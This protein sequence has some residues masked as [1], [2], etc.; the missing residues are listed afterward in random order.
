MAIDPTLARGVQQ[1]QIAPNLMSGF[2]LGQ[3]I[4]DEPTR[5]KQ[6]GLGLREDQR[7]DKRSRIKDMQNTAITAYQ[8]LGDNFDVN[9]LN[10][11]NIDGTIDRLSSFVEIESSGDKKKDVQGLINMYQGAKNFYQSEMAARGGLT[12]RVQ[13][14][15]DLGGGAVQMVFND[16]TTSVV[17][18]NPEQ[19]RAIKLAQDKNIS[20]EEA[21]N[22]ARGKGRAVGAGE[23]QAEVSSIVAEAEAEVNEAKQKSGIIGKAAGEADVERVNLESAMPTLE[24]V[25]GKLKVLSDTATHTAAGKIR[26]VIV[27]EFGFNVGEGATASAQYGSIV[28]NQVLP[29]LKATLGAA[30]TNEE[31]K[32]LEATMGDQSL[33]APEKQAQLDSFLESKKLR[34]E[35]LQRAKTGFEEAAVGFE[36]DTSDLNARAAKLGI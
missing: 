18:P 28:S 31:R 35:D 32:A 30:F 23:G 8:V 6:V 5:K 25:V 15:N 7:N 12:K 3:A 34:L 29:L 22:K 16:G 13:S 10:V 27:R 26:D 4:A 2:G 1:A 33:S 19:M 17:T 21:L 9:S 11:D 14:T 36:V 24:K 20:Y